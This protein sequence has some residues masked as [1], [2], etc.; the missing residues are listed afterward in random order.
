MTVVLGER[1]GNERQDL[2]RHVAHRRFRPAAGIPVEER[3]STAM[4]DQPTIAGVPMGDRTGIKGG[5]VELYA[6]R[7]HQH[8]SSATGE[9][10]HQPAS[11]RPLV[12]MSRPRPVGRGTTEHARALKPGKR[13]AYRRLRPGGRGAGTRALLLAILAAFVLLLGMAGTGLA[14]ER[15]VVQDGDTL[16]SVAATFGVD[17][18]AIA[19]S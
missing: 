10:H 4:A 19:A 17:P 12:F 3:R 11:R 6:A 13:T 2:K 18:A 16:G 8:G 5:I 15:Y 9:E 7:L 14:Q 1:L